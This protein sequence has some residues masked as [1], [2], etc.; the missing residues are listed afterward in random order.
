MASLPRVMHD[1]QISCLW[2]IPSWTYGIICI[3]M[4]YKLP[5]KMH[6]PSKFD[7]RGPSITRDTETYQYHEATR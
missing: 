4:T 7:D 1:V 2:S 6:L 3:V 5:Q